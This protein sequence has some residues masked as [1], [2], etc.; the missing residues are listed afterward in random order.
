MMHLLIDSSI[1][2]QD[3]RRE[4]AG[5]QAIE[6]LAKVGLITLHIPYVVFW[7]FVTQ[8]Q[9]AYA[10]NVKAV[11]DAI[12]STKG[13]PVNH[14]IEQSLKRLKDEL[15]TLKTALDKFPET[16]FMEWAK[17]LSGKTYSI[18]PKHG[19]AVMRAYFAGETPFKSRKNRNDIPDGFIWQTL[20]DL[21][22]TLGPLI[23]L[24][25]DGAFKEGCKERDGITVYETMEEFL[26]SDAFQNLVKRES[27][28]KV[29]KF[30]GE[31]LNEK[32]N[33]ITKYLETEAVEVLYDKTFSDPQIPEDNNEARIIG[34][35]SVDGVD[36]DLDRIWYLGEGVFVV[37][38]TLK[39]T[40]LVDYCI[41][42]A[43][44]YGMPSERSE[45]IHVQDWNDH[46]FLAEETYDLVVHGTLAVRLDSSVEESNVKKADIERLLKDAEIKFDEF[47]DISVVEPPYEY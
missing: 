40:S 22:K 39:C 33:N 30:L 17:R 36:L 3:P 12:R 11:E 44:Y 15:D 19:E 43:D 35:E 18:D 47:E 9:A 27:T 2:R 20:L 6:H 42:K 46:Y 16:E 26:E 29:I 25:N 34:V 45:S 28:D 23:V 32:P 41:F 38:F 8:Q 31:I 37:P 1:Y 5:F 7:E 24:A 21:H 10:K 13:I 14:A 4:K